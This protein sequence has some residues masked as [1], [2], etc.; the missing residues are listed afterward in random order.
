MLY[1]DTNPIEEHAHGT[2]EIPVRARVIAYS[3]FGV[4]DV[5]LYWRRAGDPD[6]SVLGMTVM[7]APDSFEAFVP[8]P[9][10][11]T[12]V[13]YHVSATDLSPPG[14]TTTRPW[15]AP[16]H[17]YAFEVVSD[18]VAI[19]ED[20]VPP[21]ITP[22]AVPNPF[23]GATTITGR[24]GV[25]LIEVFSADGRRVRTLRPGGAAGVVWDGRD[26]RGRDVAPGVYLVR[27]AGGGTARMLEVVKLAR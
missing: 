24:P 13:E 22:V 12:T 26:E 14:R 20:P 5:D 17:A 21:A 18:P 6:W 3:G 11:G 10:I 23:H 8:E 19:G 9:E 15:V 25:T 7:S 1:V 27:L 2:G 16:D 4:D